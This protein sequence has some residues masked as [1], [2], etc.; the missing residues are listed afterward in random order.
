[1]TDTVAVAFVHPA[2]VS[3][4]FTM[5]LLSTLT[6]DVAFH[7]RILGGPRS[8]AV[9]R[10]FSSANVSSARNAC[11]SDFLD[12]TEADWLWFVD[13]DMS[14]EEDALERLLAHADAEKAP[15]IGALCFTTTAEDGGPPR[16]APTMYGWTKNEDT[17]EVDF[18]RYV[19]FEED[20][21]VQVG[22]T[23]AAFLLIH[24]RV[25]LAMR[26]AAES[27][28]ASFSKTFV[29]FQETE[30]AGRVCGEDITFC[31]RAGMLGY[32][33]WVHTGIDVGHHKDRILN[34]EGFRAERA[35]SR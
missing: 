21:V 2:Q 35:M 23:G 28:R 4:Y 20:A 5:S 31:A 9:I 18:Y 6:R 15:I 22:A 12:N 33:V 7:R 10:K 25:L 26:E 13:T 30:L 27:G 1:M 3:T 32:P 16:H 14:W 24:R 11:V 29:W 34:L 17:G 19:D 8:G